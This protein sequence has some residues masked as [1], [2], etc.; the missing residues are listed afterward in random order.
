MHTTG[1]QYQR[2]RDSLSIYAERY[3]DVVEP[4]GVEADALEAVAR[5][6]VEA[7][8]PRGKEVERL[9]VVRAVQVQDRAR[10]QREEVRCRHPDVVVMWAIRCA[11]C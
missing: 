6:Q 3:L 2:V 10:G 7:L 5:L 11:S 1:I 8:Q 9:Q 4:V